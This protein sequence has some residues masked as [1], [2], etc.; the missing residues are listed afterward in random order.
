[1][2]KAKLTHA[3]SNVDA[4]RNRVLIK[5]DNDLLVR[6]EAKLRGVNCPVH[7]TS[8]EI[9]LSKEKSGYSVELVNDCCLKFTALCAEK[10]KS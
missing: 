1:M 3:N 9:R 6:F 10:L 4:V 7:G 8:P 2:F 5:A